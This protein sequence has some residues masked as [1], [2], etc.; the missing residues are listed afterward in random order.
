[1]EKNRWMWLVTGEFKRPKDE[2]R[3]VVTRV[4]GQSLSEGPSCKQWWANCFY[5]VAVLLYFGY[6]FKK[7]ATFN[8]FSVFHC[9]GS[10][11]VTSYCFFKCNENFTSFY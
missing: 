7:L 3:D 1:M 11:T 9:N 5:S 2:H 8:L 10:V 4:P 6:W